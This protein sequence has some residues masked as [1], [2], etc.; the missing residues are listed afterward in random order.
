MTLWSSEISWCQLGSKLVGGLLNMKLDDFRNHLAQSLVKESRCGLNHM[1]K[2]WCRLMGWGWGLVSLYSCREQPPA[3]LPSPLAGMMR[4]DQNILCSVYAFPCSSFLLLRS[5]C[6]NF[7][8][9]LLKSCS[10]KKEKYLKR[11]TELWF[12]YDL[13]RKW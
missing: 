3:S 2:E 6:Y 8:K 12:S 11:T 9:P 4:F 5:W 10:R 13:I 1:E 7:F